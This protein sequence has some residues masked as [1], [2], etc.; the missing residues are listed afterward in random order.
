MNVK[1]YVKVLIAIVSAVFTAAP[2]AAGD[3][4]PQYGGLVVET[5]AGDM[6]LVAKSDLIVIHV[7]NHGKPLKLTA[8]SG[9]VTVFNGS[10]QTEAPI[11]L[12][13][14]RLEAKGSFKIGAGTKVLAE[15]A[16]NGKAAVVARF[17]LK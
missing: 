11:T 16:L 15:V 10:E 2:Q 6:E 14:D 8:A 12:A 3:H 4:R 9:K 7:S 1:V 5:R 13:G 17:T